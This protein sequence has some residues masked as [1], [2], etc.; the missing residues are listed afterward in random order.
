[1]HMTTSSTMDVNDDVILLTQMFD[2]YS[3]ARTF[4]TPKIVIDIYAGDLSL[5]KYY[6][7]R[8]TDCIAI[9]YDC[10]KE[11]EAMRTVPRYM[12]PRVYY[13]EQNV[14]HLT[15]QDIERE[16]RKAMPDASMADVYHIHASP[17]CTTMSTAECRHDKNAY[18]LPDGSPNPDAVPY[19]R[20]RVAMHDRAM[21]QVLNMLTAIC[22][23]WPRILQTIENPH[24]AFA[25]QPQ[26]LK[27]EAS[28]KYKLLSTNYCAAADPRLDRGLWSMKPTHI[29][30][31]GACDDLQLPQCN[32]DCPYLIPGTRRH[33]MSI[34]IDGNSHP[35]QKRVTGHKR[36]AIPSG[37][38]EHITESHDSATQ[39]EESESMPHGI[40]NI[41][42]NSH[43]QKLAHDYEHGTRTLAVHC[44]GC[45]KSMSH[46]AA[47]DSEAAQAR[48]REMHARYGHQSDRR[49]GLKKLKGMEKVRCP[50]CLAAKMCRKSH[51]GKLPRAS[52][53]LELVY[54]DL[55]EFRETDIDG[56]KYQAIFVDDKTDRKWCY[57][58]KRKSDFGEV[59][60]LWLSEVGVPPTRMK[61]DWGG[62]FRSAV[63]HQFL[64]ICLERGIWPEKS[65]PYSPEQNKAER[66]NRSLLEIA[67][68]TMIHKRLPKKYW[69]YAMKYAC[70]IDMHCESKRVGMSPFKAWFGYDAVFDPPVF[71]SEVYFRHNERG[72]DKLDATGHRARFLGFPTDSPGCYVQ[73]LD[74]PSQ[75][76]RISYDVPI[77]AFDESFETLDADVVLEQDQYELVVPRLIAPGS[78]AIPLVGD[79]RIGVPKERAEYW[80]AFQKF[81]GERKRAL[82]DGSSEEENIKKIASEWKTRQLAAASELKQRMHSEMQHATVRSMQ[83]PPKKTKTNEE[84]PV[85]QSD[86]HNKVT[87]D[88]RCEKCNSPDDEAN[89]LLCDN[90]DKGYHM[91]CIGMS[92]LPAK[93]HG[94][95]CNSC[96][97][98]QTRVSVYRNTD[99]SWNDGTITMQYPHD[100]GHDIEYDDGCR[101]HAN[102]NYR[103]WRPIYES[104]HAVTALYANMTDADMQHG[105]FVYNV[106]AWCP[107]T[108]NDI[109]K[110]NPHVRDQWLKS[111]DKEWS[112]I[113]NKNAIKIIPL[114]NVPRSAVFVPT[115][116]AY[117]VK[118]D[119]TLKSRLCILGNKMPDSDF[120]TSA[121]TPRMSSVRTVLKKT[122]EEDLDCHI[123][124]LTAAFL[125]APARG[126]TYLRLPPG[127][128]KPGFAALLLRNLYG[129]T[130]A[131]RA[132][133]NML[134]NWF[135]SN[136]F[137]SNPHDPCVYS[138][139]VLGAWMHALV[140]VDD[141][142]YC[143][144]TEQCAIFR[145]DIESQFKIDYLGRL[146]IDDR[147]RRYLGVQVDRKVDRFILHNDDNITK[148]LQTAKAYNLP[149]EEVPMRDIRL[150]SED[151]PKTEEEKKAMKSKPYR[152]ILGQI[153]FICLTTRPD[154]CYGYKELARFSN[155][156]GEKHWLALLSLLGYI[157]DT[158]LTHRLHMS[159]GSGMKLRAWTDADWNGEKD[160]HL[161]TTGWITFLGDTPISWCSRMQRCTAKSTAESEY[162]AAS[163]CTQEV[164][165]LQM[166]LASLDHPTE[167]VEVFA[168]Q[169]SDDDPGCVT[170]WRE[171]ARDHPETLATVNSDSMNAIANATMPPGWLQETL[172]HIKTHFHFVKQFIADKS[173]TLA[174]CSSEDQRADIFT[175]GF[176]AKS[177]APGNNQKAHSFKRLAKMCLGM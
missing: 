124:D 80:H 136:G 5:A 22:D 69:G 45:R 55:Q 32:F 93:A 57:L 174:H 50:T 15:I 76:V 90:C 17:D 170:R 10:K 143:G 117:R 70:Y 157:R 26:V 166:L 79:D 74:N 86:N 133:H 54:T 99:K 120:E 44:K 9:C 47:A 28:G 123:L 83:Q 4:A 33:L 68:A 130:H 102:L 2:K 111:E 145:K 8:Y 144:T 137:K 13:V 96:L 156:P 38:F 98:P 1:M 151:C 36:H 103:R 43:S 59:F 61:S 121:P 51:S 60:R 73:D 49:I 16:I 66:G 75:P 146:G 110:S 105:H 31:H 97:T 37:L 11:E 3:H 138:K 84:V 148:M 109:I 64:K 135:T 18:R 77:H 14:C 27:M 25:M 35:A 78:E 147:A 58:I 63:E 30:I 127:R 82:A 89:M 65:A 122:I 171:W 113:L 34:R 115:K 169:G 153:G 39:S 131:P 172:R 85:A 168:R 152:Q 6:L 126:Q 106:A 24:G 128:N 176:G 114:S 167:T 116:W 112:A 164:I 91:K 141:I 7:K 21:N 29:L 41:L 162:V 95:L 160:K 158:R 154:C 159:R 129:S 20:N 88:T 100:G 87:A 132:W 19:R 165:Y 140:H 67:R 119:G 71:G 134:H 173:I 142:C 42:D 155:N 101:E 81:A 40:L 125:N 46:E 53:A 92:R 62:E 149:K 163:S 48:W 56:N 23:R 72:N 94:W 161:S 107:K 104:T 150:S 139:Y 175:K 108:H 12:R 177:S 118:S 52:Y